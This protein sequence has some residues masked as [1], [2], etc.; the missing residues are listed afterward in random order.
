MHISANN[1]EHVFL[2]SCVLY[3]LTE[4]FACA[5]QI[6]SAERGVGR[7]PEGFSDNLTLA[8]HRKAAAYTAEAAQAHLV[9]A[10]AATAFGAAMTAGHGLIYVTALLE[11]LTTNTLL[12]QWALIICVLALMSLVE[13]PVNWITKYRLK[14]R[15]GYQHRS[16]AEWLRR[17]AGFTTAGWAVALPA[18]AALLIL[19]ELS[20]G[21]WWLV[22]WAV[23]LCRLLWRW[24]LSLMRG[25]LWSRT[26]RPMHNETLRRRVRSLLAEEGFEMED[27]VL[28]TR[29]AVWKHAHVLLPGSGRTRRVVVF[30]DT[31][32]RLRPDELLAIIAGQLARARMHHAR[33]R[34]VFSALTSLLIC[35][36]A[37]WCSVSEVFFR[38]IG[39]APSLTVAQ[40]GS[41]AGFTV[42][43]A[44]VVFPIVFFPLRALFNYASRRLRYA[45]D[46]AAARR[47]GG[48][49][50]VRALAKLHRDYSNTLTPSAFYSLMHY[51]RPHAGM[52][53]AQILREMRARGVEPLGRDP[54][55]DEPTVLAAER[56]IELDLAREKRA[57]AV[58]RREAESRLVD[59]ILVERE[60]VE[61]DGF[62]ESADDEDADEDAVADAPESA[63]EAG[64]TD[65]PDE[66]P[67][68]PRT[69]ASEP[70]HG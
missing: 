70:A 63:G 47:M 51:E 11:T 23:F 46:R 17:T 59:S 29:P 36:A 54:H 41:H 22:L 30:A 62:D 3:V 64:E 45:A 61:D 53:V 12:V 40:P 10:F 31:A 21:L 15:F 2:I 66:T 14:E 35:A 16:R 26:S 19:F 25:R 58:A 68:A 18:T 65:G 34:I 27:L 55:P 48:D 49:A 67:A 37:G 38:G 24:K 28:M 43:A 8:A 52:R 32:A 39:F 6:I 57:F 60:I 4:C 13:L 42:A 56:K 50:L 20:G 1:I 9:Q 44:L 69:N 33:W 7:V 5:R